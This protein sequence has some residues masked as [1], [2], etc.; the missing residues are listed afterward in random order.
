[1]KK[2]LY[3]LAWFA[4]SYGTVTKEIG[5][6]FAA[7]EEEAV[8]LIPQHLEAGSYGGGEWNP[9]AF[10]TCELVDDYERLIWHLEELLSVGAYTLPE[11]ILEKLASVLMD[12]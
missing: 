2:E 3:R 12:S 11:P 10:F 1:M 5:L 9:S 7:S 8:G 6:V 4:D